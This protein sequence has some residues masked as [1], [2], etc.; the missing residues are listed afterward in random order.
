MTTMSG[1]GNIP[2][3]IHVEQGKVTDAT[4]R[5]RV[6]D[7]TQSQELASAFKS[8]GRKS[9][10]DWPDGDYRFEGGRLTSMSGGSPR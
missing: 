2:S 5:S 4:E 8:E 7:L 10:N 6:I 1:D 9:P 3:T